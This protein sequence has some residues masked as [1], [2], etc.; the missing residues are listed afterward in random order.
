MNR[1]EG[2]GVYMGGDLLLTSNLVID[3]HEME[4]LAADGTTVCL[5]SPFLQARVVQHMATD[6]YDSNVVVVVMLVLLLDGYS[7]G[8]GGLRRGLLLLNIWRSGS[9]GCGG[10]GGGSRLQLWGRYSYV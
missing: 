8:R 1:V 2:Q 3:L 10:S 4:G 5:C 9:G 6:L 7:G